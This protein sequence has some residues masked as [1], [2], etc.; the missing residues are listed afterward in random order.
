MAALGQQ[1]PLSPVP[2]RVRSAPK[3]PVRPPRPEL[4]RQ[5]TKFRR[6]LSIVVRHR[7]VPT[8]VYDWFTEGFDTADLKEAKAL[9]EALK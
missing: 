1:S 6:P 2:I 7:R 3:L 9:L 5:R 4:G 8:P